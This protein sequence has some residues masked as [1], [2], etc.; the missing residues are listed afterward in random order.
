M[1][2]PNELASLALD[3]AHVT[4]R[5]AMVCDFFYPN[6][7]GIEE[8]IYH[9]SQCLV[10]RGH[11]VVVVTHS[12]GDRTGI[13]YI[14]GGVKV[15]HIPLP[16]MLSQNTFPTFWI[17]F[18]IFRKILIR[19][20]ITIV[21][22]HQCFS[23]MTEECLFYAKTMGYHTVFTDHSL[24]GFNDMASIHINKIVKFVLSDIDHIICVSHTSKENL[25]LRGHL[26]PYMVSVIPNAVDCNMFTPNPARRDHNNI[27]IVVLARLTYRKG[28]DLLV[29]VIPQICRLFPKVNF[30]VGG[31]GPKRLMLEEM[32]EKF[33]LYDRVELLGAVPHKDV[34]EVMTRGHIFLNTSLTEAFCIA[35]VEAAS[36]GLFVVSTRVGGIPEVLPP[37]M[38]KLAEPVPE[39]LVAA[40]AE[41]IAEV[42][43]APPHK[44]HEE[45]RE[46]YSWDDVSRRTEIVYQHAVR[47][48]HIPLIERLRRYYGCGPFAGKLFVFLAAMHFLFFK[49][50]EWLN[51]A[52][53]I[54]KAPDF[55]L[56]KYQRAL[57]KTKNE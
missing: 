6:N 42:K 30:V 2:K 52:D 49:F 10:K 15:Y 50:L 11:K 38:R 44:I 46:L 55:S 36:C 45:V 57:N 23:C 39:D 13:R 33:R 25:S 34:R 7:G 4:H 27:T 21:H 16:V 37:H 22:G 29:D 32:V 14:T 26:N 9:I 5:I 18:D 28:I 43:D 1:S 24:V 51:P 41:A 54:E 35:I 31:D 48:A 53:S 40:L 17:A 3:Q 47:S 20:K 8:H 12:Y 56:K 19:E